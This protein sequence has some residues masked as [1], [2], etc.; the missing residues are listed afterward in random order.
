M[1]KCG[2]E[3]YLKDKI[4]LIHRGLERLLPK[5]AVDPPP[6]HQAMRYAV[7]G[8]GK[9]IRPILTLA[10]SEA[11]GGREEDGL[12]PA[13]AIEM[14]H[15]YSLIHDDLPC[16]DNADMRRGRPSCHK[17]FGEAIALL[18]GDGLLT[19]AFQVLSNIKKPEKS[20][21]LIREIGAAVG[22]RG[23][24][25]GQVEDIGMGT[26]GLNKAKLEKMNR[27]KTGELIKVS[28]L[29]GAV[30]A[31]AKRAEERAILSYGEH[32]GFAFQVVDDIIDRDG[33]LRVM[34]GRE[35]RLKARFLIK[36]A[37]NALSRF[38]SKDRILRLIADSIA[39]R[40]D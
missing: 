34:S 18:A 1:S 14:I 23:M 26:C 16:M 32:L 22:T 3:S 2:L 29:A 7:F 5:G 25:G 40:Q 17:K 8:G 39:E 31:E 4:A 12:I 27:R 24:I 15:S 35:A 37:K 6:V 20:C 33:Y 19:L 38:G 21:R 36:K 11:L 10:V 30:M 9:R 28:C 13:C